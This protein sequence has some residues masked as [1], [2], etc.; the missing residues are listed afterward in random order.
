MASTSTDT[1]A[2][3][4]RTPAMTLSD[5]RTLGAEWRDRVPIVAHAEW[6][7]P[8]NRLDPVEILIEQGKSRIPELLP[9]R[10]IQHQAIEFGEAGTDVSG[11]MPVC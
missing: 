10:L 5:R 11:P 1:Y 8:A 9:V 6:Q 7:P 2:H 4:R 3:P